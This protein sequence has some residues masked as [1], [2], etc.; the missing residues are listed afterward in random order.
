MSAIVK[1]EQNNFNFD[2][3][4]PDNFDIYTYL[5]ND[6]DI[7]FILYFCQQEIIKK[8]IILRELYNQDLKEHCNHVAMLAVYMGILYNL[9]KDRL[10][11]LG[12][13][14]LLHDIGKCSI[15]QKVLNKPTSLSETEFQ[16]VQSHSSIGY[17]ALKPYGFSEDILDMVLY[18]HEK[19]DGSGYP[20]G[21]TQLSIEV[22]LLTIA[23]MFDAIISKRVYHKSHTFMETINILEKSKGLNMT[24]I[25]ILKKGIDKL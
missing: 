11:H 5:E 20:T 17:R 15:T 22:Q 24:A 2:T 21:E 16:L 12:I 13:G 1:E 19:L 4:V 23:D 8:G 18:H 3:K 25:G 14:S 6:N 9:D 10:I 7:L